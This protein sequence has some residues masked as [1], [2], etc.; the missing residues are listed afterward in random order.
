M[1]FNSLHFLIFFPVVLTLSL[2]L[3]NKAQRILLLLA[4]LYF[5]MAWNYYFIFLL[6]FSIVIDYYAG[7]SIS[8]MQRSDPKR[9]L[10]L[11]LSLVT[12]L[13]FLGYFKYTNFFLGVLNDINIWSGFR[14]PAYD[15]IL[16]VGISFYTF[17]SMSYTIDVYRGVTPARESFL[18]FALYVSFFPQLVAGPIVRAETFFRD[19]E[20]RLPVSLDVI[21]FCFAQILL[22]FTKKVVFA[23]NL[24]LC[25]DSVFSHHAN[26]S[27]L[28]IWI[29]VY[30]FMWQIYFDFSGYTDIAIGVAR[31]F[32]FKF[33][34]NFYFPFNVT[35][36]SEHWSRWH[37]SFTSW[38]RDYIFIPLG[39]S[40]VSRWRVHFNIFI[41]FL[42]GGIWHGAAYHFLAW[43]IWH[44]IMLSVEREF[45][46]TRLRAFLN[47]KGGKPYLIFCYFFTMFCLGLG[48]PLFRAPSMTDAYAMLEKMFFLNLSASSFSIQYAGYGKLVILLFITGFIFERY[49][50]K[51]MLENPR[52]FAL[53]ILVNIFLLLMYGVKEAQNFIYFAF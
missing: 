13:G 46:S 33:D 14:F 40:K 36:I 42:F 2:I 18:D 7:L 51:K 53:F 20:N 22:G 29:G 32:G 26:L 15:I 3:K 28:D 31:L 43:G 11:I 52:S 9:K 8:K 10:Y 16:P 47:E 25:V 49:K 30:A 17:Q 6:L 1:L 35:S 4:S 41:T 37:I 24:S 45:A 12:N 38:I 50:L 39:G 5:Y 23:D 19:L 44:S 34:V 21:R 48:L 27:S